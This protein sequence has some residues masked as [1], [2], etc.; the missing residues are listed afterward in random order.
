MLSRVCV[1]GALDRYVPFE[2]VFVPVQPV[3]YKVD[4]FGR[5]K[6]VLLSHEPSKLL[7]LLSD[8]REGKCIIIKKVVLNAVSLL[9]F[10][11]ITT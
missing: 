10:K 3:S 4:E 8:L 1:L 7:Q 6:H 11:K 2:S 9:R 5:E